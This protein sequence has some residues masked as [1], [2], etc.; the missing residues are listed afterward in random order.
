MPATGYRLVGTGSRLAAPR[1][2]SC[3]RRRTIS[4]FWSWIFS[5]P[6]MIRLGGRSSG[7]ASKMCPQVAT[8]RSRTVEP[9]RTKCDGAGPD[10]GGG[11]DDLLHV[12]LSFWVEGYVPVRTRGSCPLLA[13]SQPGVPWS[14]PGPFLSIAHEED[15]GHHACPAAQRR[16]QPDRIEGGIGAVGSSVDDDE[17]VHGCSFTCPVGLVSD[18]PPNSSVPGRAEGRTLCEPNF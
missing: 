13:S 1:P 17:S 6:R 10:D 8:A 3:S 14:R 15:A 2:P 11:D 5:M 16:S 12:G 7:R 9:N 4:A 18:V